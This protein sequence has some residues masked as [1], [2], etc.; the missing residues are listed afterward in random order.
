MLLK[1]PLDIDDA[2]TLLWRQTAASENFIRAS[3]IACG[4]EPRWRSA[5]EQLAR[6]RPI[7]DAIPYDDEPLYD[8]LGALLL[9]RR[10]HKNREPDGRCF[11]FRELGFDCDRV[12]DTAQRIIR[13]RPS[14]YPNALPLTESER[15]K[16]RR[17]SKFGP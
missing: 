6:L 12:N 17:F 8:L 15:E 11:I 3:I 2:Y 4:S 14:W 5:I 10:Q 1:E 13:S 7:W 9:R 16:C